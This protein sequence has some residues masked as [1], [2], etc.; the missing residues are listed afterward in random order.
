MIL[1]SF[2]ESFSKGL[3]TNE[4][5]KVRLLSLLLFLLLEFYVLKLK[6]KWFWGMFHYL[7]YHFPQHCYHYHHLQQQPKIL[8]IMINFDFISLIQAAHRKKVFSWYYLTFFFF[9]EDRNSYKTKSKREDLYPFIFFFCWGTVITWDS[10]RLM[11]LDI[12]R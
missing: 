7:F 4:W 6:L 3:T 10:L 9:F 2:R 12:R 1:L 8:I 11:I 5:K